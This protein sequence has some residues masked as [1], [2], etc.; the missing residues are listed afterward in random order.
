MDINGMI[1][2]QSHNI[3][4]VCPEDDRARL[5]TARVSGRMMHEMQRPADY[6]AVGDRVILAWDG[7]ESA[8]IRGLHPRRSCLTR[9]GD[10]NTQQAQVIAA[11][12]DMLLICTSLNRDFSLRRMER[13]LAAAWG[14]GVAPVL[15]LTKADLAPDAERIRND[16]CAA[17]PG[18]EVLLSGPE[19]PEAADFI[20]TQLAQGKYLAL[21]GS[22]GVGKSTLINAV[23]EQDAM[24]TSAIRADDDRGR[25]T[26]THR[27]LIFC[28]AGAVI[29][30]PGM[31]AFALDEADVGDAFARIAELSQGCRFRDCTHRSEPGCAVKRAV[32][33]GELDAEQLESY[34]RLHSESAVRKKRGKLLIKR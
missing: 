14:G 24:R 30:T 3:Y 6:P 7:G 19:Q 32:A 11:N 12:L 1:I 31:R 29:D 27:Q 33:Q 25:H 16:V 21:A 23:L 4:T 26:T 17:F 20:R 22:S 13:Y 34:I 15:V 9:V 5:L 28:G 2:T 18:V 8:V 10:M